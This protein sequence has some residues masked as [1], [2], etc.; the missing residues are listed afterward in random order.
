MDHKTPA[1]FRPDFLWGAATSAYQVEG[2]WD[3]DGKGPSVQDARGNYPEGTTDFKVA[4]DH[5]H[6]FEE[7]VRLF[8]ELG[9]KAYRLSIA[10]TRIVP[11]GDGA[12]NPDGIAFYHRLFDTLLTHGIEPVVT[13]YHFDLP[14]ALQDK[15]GWTSRS[16]IDAFAR[17]CE[18]LFEEYGSKVKHWLTI[19]EQNMMI[20]HGAAI[21]TAGTTSDHP[22]REL[23]QQNHHMMVAQARVTKMCHDM[24]PAAKI[25]PAPNIS[26]VYP[27]SCKP[28]DVLAAS[29]YNAIRNWLYLDMAVYGTYNPTAWAW[30]TA[31]GIAP[32]FAEDDAE[33]LKAGTADFLA[34]NYYSTAT[35]AAAEGGEAVDSGVCDQQLSAGEAGV[36]RP[37][38]NPHLAT[39]EFGWEID[40]VGFRSTLRDVYDRYRLPI[41]VT[42]NGLGGFDTVE[43]GEIHDDYRIA[44]LST[45]IEQMRLAVSDGVD[46]IGYHPWSAMDLISTHQGVAKRYGF[47]YVDRDEFDLKELRRI[48]KD[49][50][51]W[52]QQLIK[53]NGSL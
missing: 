40:P 28:E 42:E 14:Q 36:F 34:L 38:S 19:N 39:T 2:A 6:R 26:V 45:H 31:A 29:D 50:F 35:V 51:F 37:V 11:D 23:Y 48:R 13:V 25:G 17:Y 49:S 12:V 44:Y 24:L 16:T 43:D 8:A 52:Y 30:M 7:D 33:V 5:Y 47:I 9:L 27:A 1:A 18:V 4:A 41:M 46:V 53:G 32:E 20:L 21:G 3:T 10:W 15:G 22:K